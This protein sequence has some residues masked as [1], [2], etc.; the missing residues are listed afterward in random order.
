MNAT[1]PPPVEVL[2]I[3]GSLRSGS[4]NRGLV[5]ALREIIE[6]FPSLSFDELQDWDTIPL[7]N[8]DLIVS[9]SLPAS[10]QRTVD[11]IREAD[12]VLVVTP[13][14]CYGPPGGLKNLLDWQALPNPARSSF[15]HKPVG[16]LG[17]S[18]GDLGTLRAQLALRTSFLF[19]DALVMGK[20]EVYVSNAAS[21]FDDTGALQDEA[22]RQL[23]TRFV[24]DFVEHSHSALRRQLPTLGREFLY[25]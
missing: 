1:D 11:R 5:D 3:N 19:M 24:D 4:Y 13:E 17:A 8:V 22:T 25:T 9:G 14:Y 20:P 21:K 10:V 18:I 15:R 6:G 2:V 7:V 12:A 16:V 23:L